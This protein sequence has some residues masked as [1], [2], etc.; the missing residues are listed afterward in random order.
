MIFT[1]FVTVSEIPLQIS[2]TIATLQFPPFAILIILLVFYVAIGFVMDIMPI[3]LIT[4]PVLHPVLVGMGFEP[5]WI[6]VL[7]T[8]TALIGGITPPVG[9]VVF[10]LSAMIKDVPIYTIFK[11]I[12]PFLGSMLLC[13]ALIIAFKDIVLFLPKLMSP[14]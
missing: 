7:I 14:G 6:S 11:G 4:A 12:F 2:E 8:M 10:A 5:V 9:L 13:L 3:I 1:R